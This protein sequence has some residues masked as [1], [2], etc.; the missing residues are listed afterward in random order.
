MNGKRDKEEDKERRVKDCLQAS[1]TAVIHSTVVRRNK[2]SCHPYPPPHTRPAPVTPAQQRHSA[3][4]RQSS[5]PRPLVSTGRGCQYYARGHRL[6]LSP[7]GLLTSGLQPFHHPILAPNTAAA[8]SQHLSFSHHCSRPPRITPRARQTRQRLLRVLYRQAKPLSFY[9][10]SSTSTRTPHEH[11]HGHDPLLPSTPAIVR[12]DPSP[13]LQNTLSLVAGCSTPRCVYQI[14]QPEHLHWHSGAKHWLLRPTD[15]LPDL[16]PPLARLSL[17]SLSL[18]HCQPRPPGHLPGESR[19]CLFLPVPFALVLSPS[20]LPPSCPLSSFLEYH[21]SLTTT[22]ASLQTPLPGLLLVRPC[23]STCSNSCYLY[24]TLITTPSPPAPSALCRSESPPFALQALF[25]AIR[26]RTSLTLLVGARVPAALRVYWAIRSTSCLV[27][28]PAPTAI[29]APQ[30]WLY[31]LRLHSPCPC[32]SLRVPLVPPRCL[33]FAFPLRLLVHFQTNWSYRNAVGPLFAD[34]GSVS[35]QAS[36]PVHAPLLSSGLDSLLSC[37][38]FCCHA[39]LLLRQTAPQFFS[40][41]TEPIPRLAFSQ[42]PG[43]LPPRRCFLA[44]RSLLLLPDP[45]CAP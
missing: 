29:L 8:F 23:P 37:F 3:T 7:P 30:A 18:A 27:R 43:R 11:G 24:R 40:K 9:E 10:Y 12:R 2:Q 20:L 33:V 25:Q 26:A 45:T 22:I 14:D 5:W 34:T 13:P 42:P 36:T 28:C 31:P 15:R 38:L 4:Q 35:A 19:S 32:P 16:P 6:F 39:S 41:T 17:Q 1:L 21:D 44:S